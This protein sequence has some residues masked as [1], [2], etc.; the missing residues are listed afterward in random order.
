MAKDPAFLFYSNDFY[1]GTR[2]MLPEERAC[3][4]DLLIYQ[5]QN[6]FIPDDLK[7][8]RLFCS[9][10]DEATL[11][12]TLEAKFKLCLS[13]W[14]NEK[15]KQ[16]IENR[17]IFTGRQSV[18]GKVGQ[19]FK[20]A[21]KILSPKELKTLRAK[22]SEITNNNQDFYDNWLTKIEDP[23]AM[24]IAM[25]KHLEN[26][27][28]NEIENKDINEIRK[29]GTGE[30]PIIIEEVVGLEY[31]FFSEEFK[32]QWQLWKSYRNKEHKF[33]YKMVETEQAAM[34][35]LHAISVGNEKTAIAIIHQSIANGWK[36]F[37]EL[38]NKQNGAVKSNAEVFTNAMGSET[39]RNFRFS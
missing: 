15:L 35:E 28:E 18:N 5:H 6:G 27:I 33:K 36:G 13:G 8:L 2:M 39:A 4:L 37:F 19:F 24:L 29:G 1:S 11:K 21:A 12:A 14:Y 10:I 30:K 16:V 22:I 23:K 20:K 9:G 17:E 3:Y 31:V 26:E 7:R 25:L 34:N 32:A 38:K